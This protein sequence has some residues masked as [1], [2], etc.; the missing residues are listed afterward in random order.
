MVA[1]SNDRSNRPGRLFVVSAPSG[2]GK[3][4]ILQAVLQQQPELRFS[5]SCTTRAPRPG[6]VPGRHYHFLDRDDFAAGIRAGRFLEWAEVHGE[7]Y[8]TDG[9][10]IHRWLQAGRDVVLDIDVQ[11]ARQV[12][13]AIPAVRTLFILPPSFE[14]LMERLGNRGTE[15]P[16]QL[17]RRLG[18]AE[19]ELQEAPWYDYLVVNDRLPEAIAD[20]LA[21]IRAD[22]CSRAR[23]A[24]R[25]QAFFHP[26]RS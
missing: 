1:R 12:R 16:D 7:L 15:S 17:K 4:T 24:H 10:P 18:A 3:T 26:S 11:G 25:V 14:V 6:E 21:V 13:A 23:Q 22:R 8:G 9:S 19:R 2:V 20:C 5:V